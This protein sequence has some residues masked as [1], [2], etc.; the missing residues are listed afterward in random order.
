M[1]ISKVSPEAVPRKTTRGAGKPDTVILPSWPIKVSSDICLPGPMQASFGGRA[2]WR[3]C[4]SRRHVHRGCPISDSLCFCL[5]ARLDSELH[6]R[7]NY[8]S[9]QTSPLAHM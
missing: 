2:R 1:N 7:S 5:Q 6:I 8:R 4:A 9:R 3:G